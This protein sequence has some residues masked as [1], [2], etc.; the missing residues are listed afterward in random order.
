MDLKFNYKVIVS[1]IKKKDL[2]YNEISVPS[3][4]FLIANKTA[5]PIR[6]LITDKNKE[7]LLQDEI[8]S[9]A[10]RDLECFA[11]ELSHPDNY[12][13]ITVFRFDENKMRY[14]DESKACIRFGKSFRHA[15]YLNTLTNCLNIYNE[16]DFS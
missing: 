11:E 8:S 2:N 14:D 4:Y 10:T 12:G 13:L 3:K 1:L 6:I 5:N 15:V 7:T 9:E 16:E